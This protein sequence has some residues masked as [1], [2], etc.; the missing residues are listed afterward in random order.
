MK[1]AL[2]ARVSCEKQ[3]TDLSVSA[4]LKAL[5]EFATKNQH[6]VVKQ[7]VD[8]AESGKTADRPL[9]REMIAM[10]RRS[11]KPFDLILVWKYSRFARDRYDSMF[12]KTMLRKNGVQVVSINEPFENTPTGRL[13]EAIVEGMDE[14]YSDNLGQDV[15]RG[16][17]ESASRGFYV[18]AYAP[19]GYRKVKVNDGGKERTKLELEPH[20]ATVVAIIF[21]EA[22]EEKNLKDIVKRLNS[23]GIA[24]PRGKGWQKTTVYN[25]LTN[26]VYTGTFVWGIKSH[27][28]LAPVK[29]E[30]ACPAIAN[31]DIF[32]RVQAIMKERAP[33][34]IHPRRVNSRY[35]LSGLARCGHCGNALVGQDAKSGRFS[36][37][38]CGTLLKKGAGS[39]KAGYLRSQQFE[40]VVIEQV[41]KHILTKENLTE[42]VKLVNEE[43]EGST[44]GDRLHYKGILDEI[45]DTDCRLERLYDS[46]ETGKLRLEDLA[47][48]IQQ[49]RC[50]QEQ[51]RAI[52]LELEQ[53][54]SDKRVDVADLETITY[55]VEDLRNLLSES[56]LTDKKTFIRSFI[57]EVKVTGNEASLTYT[58]PL[59]PAGVIEEKIVV[60]PIVQYG[61][62]GWI[63]TNDQSV[64]SRPLCH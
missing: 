59:P 39:C 60:P 33:A 32:E 35:L 55:Y 34:K 12:Y 5:R 37:Y 23:E 22:L 8:E 42:L 38:V 7:F 6:E 4:Q 46:L 13:M 18:G 53:H 31:R 9:F 14:F 28:E 25:I 61:G 40:G 36:Y 26:E 62:P 20:Q 3:D 19:Y 54:L 57:K 48:R 47:P 50:R 41:K 21:E 1:V 45:A 30:N 58:L 52:Q 15:T 64:M 2:Y 10:A 56:T 44:E 11:P 49:L 43:I 17:R 63:R 27:R 24:G 51:L 16:M 29:V